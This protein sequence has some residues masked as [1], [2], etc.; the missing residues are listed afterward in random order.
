MRLLRY[1]S[2]DGAPRPGVLDAAGVPRDLSLVLPDLA[3]LAL[4]PASLE[5]LA[6][7][8]TEA[9]PPVPAGARLLPPVGGVGKIIGVGLN[10]RDHAIECRL[11]LPTE[12]TLFLKA[13]SALAGPNDLVAVPRGGHSL[14][15]EVELAVVIGQGGA[16][17]AES[18]ALDHVAG[19]CLAIDFSERE[20]QFRRGG[21]GF[22]GKSADGFGPLGPWLLTHDALPDPQGLPLR[23]EVNGAVRQQGTT[24]D[25][26]FPVAVLISY[27]SGFMSLQPGDVIL[28]GTP[29]GVGMGRKPPAY[30]RPGDEVVAGAGLLGR[31][32]HRITGPA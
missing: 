7:M 8:E 5:R 23:L 17:V 21:Q 20:F 2:T 29:S 12:P 26:I 1:V 3:G 31:Q 15:W 24:A 22:K 13:T 32:A 18:H 11:P 4:L 30:L 19:Y 27:I 14:D 28:T 25:M 9:L 10:Y 16:Y 6:G